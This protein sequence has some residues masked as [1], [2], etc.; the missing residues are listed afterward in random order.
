MANSDKQAFFEKYAPMAMEQ[1]QKYG[2]PASVTLAQMYIESAGG[3]SKL[4][5]EGNNYFGIKCSAEWVSSGKPYSLH[6]DDRPNEKF[7][8]YA[9]VEDSITHHSEFLMQPRYATCRQCA[10]DD[11]VGWSNGLQAAGYATARNYAMTIQQDIQVYGLDKY[12]R[13]A[14]EDAQRKGITIGYMRGKSEGIT[15]SSNVQQ[16]Q[17]TTVSPSSTHWSFPLAPPDGEL[18]VTSGFGYR[19]VK[20]AG[21]SHNHNGLDLRTNFAPNSRA[22]ILATEDNGKVIKVG[23]DAK[24]GNYLKVEYGRSDGSKYQVSYA[25]LSSFGVKEGDIVHAGQTLGMSGAS[26]LA[27]APGSAPHLHFVVRQLNPQ[28][29]IKDIDPT[30][31]LAEIAVRGQ[32]DQKLVKKGD[33]SHTDLLAV[34]KPNVRLD[35]DPLGQSPLLAQQDESQE[36]SND[37][38]LLAEITSSDNPKDWLNYLMSQNNDQQ[39]FV[40]GDIIS[41]L[42]SM[43]F[44]GLFAMIAMD[45]GPKNSQ[46]QSESLQQDLSAEIDLPALI[47]RKREGVDSGKMK[48]MASM[49]YESQ[50]SDE[51]QNQNLKIS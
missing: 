25:H 44:S 8:N 51:S 20:V 21:A 11:Y 50:S 42:L 38:Q 3:K 33:S 12:D 18:V 24:S 36:K 14:I 32:L 13:M 10:S 48:Q 19:N 30:Q 46:S 49:Q 4:S 45:E 22:P 15:T 28:G 40:S 43:L 31:Y 34:Y 2:I 7:C 1:Q 41:D 35:T 17:V 39:H 16:Q 5:R 9:S 26:G 6:N 23:S 47:A 29:V 27:S 37:R